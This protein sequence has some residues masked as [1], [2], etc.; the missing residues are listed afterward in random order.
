MTGIIDTIESFKVRQQT[1]L[2]LNVEFVKKSD[3]FGED[4]QSRIEAIKTEFEVKKA[5]LGAEFEKAKASYKA[6]LKA[7]FG[8]TDGESANILDLV[9]LIYRV[10]KP[11]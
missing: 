8:V 5:E 7:A 9:Q 3:E 1:I 4:C 11:E 2:D 6:D 10:A